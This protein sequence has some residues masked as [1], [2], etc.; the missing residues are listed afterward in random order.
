MMVNQ[1]ITLKL[2]FIDGRVDTFEWTPTGPDGNTWEDQKQRW[3]QA[4]R[5][6]ILRLQSDEGAVMV[7]VHALASIEIS[8]APQGETPALKTVRRVDA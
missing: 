1:Q 7:F 8:P 6:G 2:R 3:N 4:L 5:E